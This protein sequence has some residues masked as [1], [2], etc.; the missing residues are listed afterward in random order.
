MD[1]DTQGTVP[2][3]STN[4]DKCF[5]PVDFWYSMMEGMVGVKSI[6]LPLI[7]FC[8]PTSAKATH[9]NPALE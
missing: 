4:L 6:K 5:H 1:D 2:D 3:I 7:S 9:T 8:A